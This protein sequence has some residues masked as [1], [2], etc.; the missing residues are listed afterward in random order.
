MRKQVQVGAVQPREPARPGQLFPL[1][2][3][4][5]A[6][7]ERNHR[8]LPDEHRFLAE[9]RE[10]SHFLREDFNLSASR[11]VDFKYCG[12]ALNSEE[13]R[14][15]IKI[16]RTTTIVIIVVSTLFFLLA[17]FSVCVCWYRWKVPLHYFRSLPI[18]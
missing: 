1:R 17:C 11:S 15:I 8:H 3:G 12:L 14:P 2:P 16:G 18:F 6:G 5:P 9:Y 7:V 10:I 4:G 13:A